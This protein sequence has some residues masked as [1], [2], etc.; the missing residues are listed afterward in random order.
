MRSADRERDAKVVGDQDESHAA[1]FLHAREKREDLPLRRHIERRGRLVCDRAAP[2]RSRAPP[3]ARHAVASL[4]TAG[5]DS[6]RRRLRHGCRPRRAGGPPPRARRAQLSRRSADPTVSTGFSIVNGSWISSATSPAAH[7]PQRPLVQP[8]EVAAAD[9]HS[10]PRD[11]LRR[12][13]ADERARRQRL[14]AAGL[15]DDP[16]SLSGCDLQVHASDDR[17]RTLAQPR[18]DGESFDLQQRRRGCRHRAR[19]RSERRS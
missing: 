16:D 7:L 8:D 6:G 5:T 10:T 18:T 13:Q 4:P 3:R 12:K 11:A 17:P 19:P 2:G 14:A 9:G 1:R 15:P